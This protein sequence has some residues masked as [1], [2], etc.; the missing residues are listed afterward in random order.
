MSEIAGSGPEKNKLFFKSGTTFKWEGMRPDVESV[1]APSN[2]PRQLI[3]M[4]LKGGRIEGRGGQVLVAS[5]TLPIT[6]MADYF[7]EVVTVNV[8]DCP[9]ITI[10]FTN[11]SPQST[12]IADPYPLLE[13]TT[14]IASGGVAPYVYSISSGANPGG[15]VIDSSTGQL[16]NAISTPGT[17][18]FTV[19]ATDSNDCTG[20]S[21]FTIVATE[22]PV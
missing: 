16:S 12:I 18:V 17:Y 1:D 21:S 8:F 14:A 10:T 2:A 13:F 22:N 3:N 15:F 11:P 7:T 4:R 5:H 6:G 19:T 20:S 9:D